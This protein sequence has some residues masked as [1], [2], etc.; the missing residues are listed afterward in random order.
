MIGVAEERL[1]RGN[2]FR[3]CVAEAHHCASVG[4]RSHG[5]HVGVM[6]KCGGRVIVVDGNLIDLLQQ[7]IVDFLNVR[8]R[9]RSRLR[10]RSG[11]PREGHQ[12]GSAKVNPS[13]HFP[14]LT[15]PPGDFSIIEKLPT[16]A[17]PQRASERKRAAFVQALPPADSWRLRARSAN[18]FCRPD[19][20][21]PHRFRP[22]PPLPTRV[23]APLPQ[24]APCLRYSPTRKTRHL[25]AGSEI[26]GLDS[27]RRRTDRT[28]CGT[29]PPPPR[30]R[31]W[32]PPALQWPPPG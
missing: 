8:A 13:F 20:R 16:S 4:W 25:E 18:S 31:W 15:S 7:A 28:V 17:K 3:I 24:R 19:R 22:R 9:Q 11:G 27:T 21:Q 23:S 5:V 10:V 32:N 1:C 2:K 29:P 12:Q 6:R 30:Q 14:D 26:P